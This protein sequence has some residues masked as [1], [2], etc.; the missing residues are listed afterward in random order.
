MRFLDICRCQVDGGPA[1]MRAKAGI[2]DRGMDPVLALLDGG[3][4]QAHDHNGRVTVSRIDF[5]FDGVGV[6]SI[7]RPAINLG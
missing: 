3:I 2:A 6:H 5:D 4:G 7:H 1:H